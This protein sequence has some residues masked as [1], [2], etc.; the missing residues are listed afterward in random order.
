[1]SK[2]NYEEMMDHMT[3]DTFTMMIVNGDYFNKCYHCKYNKS[4]CNDECFR[5]IKEWLK[6]RSLQ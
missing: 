2:T 1:M 6:S 4:A 5:G 3:I